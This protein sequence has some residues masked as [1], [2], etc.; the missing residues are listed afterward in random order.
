VNG[1]K[2]VD[3]R[4]D[5]PGFPGGRVGASVAALAERVLA[6]D[7]LNRLHARAKSDREAV[8]FCAKVLE[9]L[10][11][12]CRVRGVES[13]AGVFRWD[14]TEDRRLRAALKPLDTVR[15]G[16]L[17]AA[18]HPLG[19]RDAL[20]MV[21]L[22]G[23]S[24]PD[25]RVLANSILARIPE[26]RPKLIAVDPFGGDGSVERNRA[27][28][29]EAL[30]WLKAGGLLGV[31][32]AG[33]VSLWRWKERR[34]ADKDWSPQIPRLASAAG[35]QVLP[36]HIGARSSLGLQV[37]AFLHPSLKTPFL[38][39]EL[40]HGPAYEL[41]ATLGSARFLKPGLRT[42]EAARAAMDLRRETYALG[43]DACA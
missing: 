21:R 3:L 14:G 16:C 20:L 17:V 32:P 37:L 19:G 9:D 5:V 27:A 8:R 10:G 35:A 31:F 6:L 4:R 25:F 33:E 36:V 12:T 7:A 15:G 43:E 38:G 11:V 18:N 39:R 2:L 41:T 40:V 26:V 23:A 1:G 30:E 13:Q 24:R 29:R 42:R 28:M 34:V 22:L